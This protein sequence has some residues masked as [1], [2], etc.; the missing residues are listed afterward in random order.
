MQIFIVDAFTS[1]RFKGNRAGVVVGAHTLSATE[2][3]QIASELNASETAF[4]VQLGSGEFSAEYY[5]PTTEVD[6]CGHATIGAFHTLALLNVIDH[7]QSKVTVHTKAGTF[8]L[9]I[10]RESGKILVGMTHSSSSIAP[11]ECSAKNVADALNITADKLSSEFPVVYS[12]TA[13]WHLM[14]GVKDR[15]T[16]DSLSYDTEKLSR[17]LN[18]GNAITAHV[19]S[20]RSNG[21]FDVRNFC[22]TVGIPEDPGTGSAAA[23]FGAYLANSGF[24]NDGKTTLQLIQGEKMGR[25]CDIEV[26]V[27]LQDRKFQHVQ[28]RGTAVP[29]YRL[30]DVSEEL[31]TPPALALAADL[32]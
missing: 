21:V 12:K 3:Q 8:P 11:L 26:E 6:F 14:I 27:A 15:D 24:L 4:L 29:S 23:A 10:S 9:V 19:F 16:L 1:E 17:L 20:A 2:K 32:S 31:L 18:Q 22:P 28:F 5:T 13:N 30:M 25:K 7:K